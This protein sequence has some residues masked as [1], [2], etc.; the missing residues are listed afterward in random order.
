MLP[1]NREVAGSGDIAL[2]AS[3]V[4]SMLVSLDNL[5]LS[6]NCDL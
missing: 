6:L 4:E 5:D 3:R 1:L 2:A